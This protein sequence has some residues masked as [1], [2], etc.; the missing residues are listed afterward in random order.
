M[1]KRVISINQKKQI[2]IKPF[3]GVTLNGT[4]VLEENECVIELTSEDGEY[5]I[6]VKPEG[7]YHDPR[8]NS[9]SEY[10]TISSE[11]AFNEVEGIKMRQVRNLYKLGLL[12][13]A[14]IHDHLLLAKIQVNSGNLSVVD[15]LPPCNRLKIPRNYKARTDKITN[16]IDQYV[17][18]NQNVLSIYE[19][20]ASVLLERIEENRHFII[21]KLILDILMEKLSTDYHFLLN[22]L[23]NYSPYI[24]YDRII[25]LTTQLLSYLKIANNFDSEAS[26][27][28]KF[29]ASFESADKKNLLR[30]LEDFIEKKY[31]HTEIINMLDRSRLILEI[32]N[33][34]LNEF[35]FERKEGE[36][37]RG[38]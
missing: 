30:C 28:K 15:Y 34:Y 18:L 37:P 27:L 11:I 7:L 31:D 38:R 16:V 17:N 32:I 8:M 1:N 26:K 22:H 12:T 29:S 33:D 21:G 5:F 25:S 24:L 2:I 10:R 36:F 19:G 9:S 3:K 20:N 23:E 4:L 35:S 13:T 6:L 14:T